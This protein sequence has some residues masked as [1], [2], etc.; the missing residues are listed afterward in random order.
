M[1]VEI[2]E[3]AFEEAIEWGLLQYGPDA[4][5]SPGAEPAIGETQRPYGDTAPGGYRKRR[6][7]D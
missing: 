2:S 6:P 5:V 7:E 3:R 4:S 1:S